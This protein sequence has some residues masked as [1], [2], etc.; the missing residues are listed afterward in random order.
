[1]DM[2]YHLADVKNKEVFLNQLSKYEEELS[3]VA[4][5]DVILVAYTKDKSG[6]AH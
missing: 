4:G 6:A 2:N 1:M 5:N 3:T